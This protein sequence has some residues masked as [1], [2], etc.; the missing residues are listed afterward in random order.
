MLYD[1]STHHGNIITIHREPQVAYTGANLVLKS[2]HEKRMKQLGEGA[3]VHQPRSV[4]HTS[5]Q[6]NS[7]QPETMIRQCPSRKDKVKS[8]RIPNRVLR[9]RLFGLVHG[10]A[11]SGKVNPGRLALPG[12]VLYQM[13]VNKTGDGWWEGAYLE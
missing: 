12:R 11:V 10:A 5:V 9:V 3:G 13:F 2:H 7:P 6:E 8:L 4:P 1:N